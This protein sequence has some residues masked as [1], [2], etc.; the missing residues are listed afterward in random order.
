MRVQDLMS[1]PP[2]TCHVN[3]PLNLAAHLLWDHDCGVLPVVTDEGKIAGM[4]TDRD[5]CMAAFTQSRRID[6]ILAN[7]AMSQH[8]VTVRPEQSVAEVEELMSRHQVRRLPVVD[9]DGKPVGVISLSDLALESTRPDTR[10]KNGLA[11]VARTLAAVCKP[12]TLA[13]QAA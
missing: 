10:M 8:I 3:D 12:R 6:E 9:G 4:I 2:V 1:H 5:I 7:S 13:Q 11:E